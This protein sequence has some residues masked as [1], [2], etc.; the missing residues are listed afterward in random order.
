MKREA[1]NHTKMERVYP[2]TEKEHA[3]LASAM[4]WLNEIVTQA[5]VDR[6]LTIMRALH[7]PHDEWIWAYHGWELPEQAGVYQFYAGHLRLY[8]GHA[9]N[10]RR[11]M[12]GHRWKEG[13]ICGRRHNCDPSEMRILYR[14]MLTLKEAR[15]YE[16][17]LIA[18]HQ[19]P[20]NI[21]GRRR[22]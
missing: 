14:T 18:H 16:V 19:P 1:V 20:H 15:E 4:D 13:Y 8:I 22:A 12:A 9:L 11:R 10:L 5:N 17:Q 7:A 6:V 3:E 2:S 21:A